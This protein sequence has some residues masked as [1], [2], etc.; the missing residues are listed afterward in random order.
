MDASMENVTNK[1]AVVKVLRYGERLLELN[2]THKY[3]CAVAKSLSTRF[4]WFGMREDAFRL[5]E[6]ALSLPETTPGDR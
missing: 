1:E 6:I 4:S 2:R 5:A 3:A